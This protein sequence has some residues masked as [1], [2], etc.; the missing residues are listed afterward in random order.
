MEGGNFNILEYQAVGDGKTLC[1]GAIQ[2]AIDDAAKNGGKVIVPAGIYLSGSLQ[3]R[4]HMELHLEEGAVLRCSLREEDMLDFSKDFEDDNADTGWE[5]GC[6]LYA[7]HVKDLTI[8][9][10]GKIDG[11]GREVFFDDD[12]EG[13]PHEGPLNVRGFRP[14]LSFLED[15]ENLCIRDVTFYDAAY[16]TLHLAG[17]RKVRIENI[18]IEN[19]KR[20]V[21]SDGIDPDSCQD[22]IIRGCRIQTGDDS[23]VLKS[24]APMYQKYGD[25]RDILINNCI[26]TTNCSALKI[27]TETYGEVHDVILSDCIVRDCIRG[28]GIWSRDGGRIH[29][30]Y[31]H[32][33]IGTT[34]NFKDCAVRTDGICSWWGEGEP[35]FLSATRRAGVDRIPG[36]IHDIYLDHIHLEGEAPIVMAGETYAPIS[37]VRISDSD[38]V[39]RRNGR[40]VAFSTG[41]DLTSYRKEEG[42]CLWEG[43][44]DERPSAADRKMAKIPYI[45]LRHTEDVQ[46]S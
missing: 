13:A 4:S 44:L 11:Q 41:E 38:F 18:V 8:S 16:W 19:N 17:C 24:T 35:V 31:A 5:G 25:C 34:R 33:I 46:F 29:H 23:I 36:R 39:I 7:C 32:H 9:G 22:V 10:T 15:V 1:T 37:R 12:P 14:R 42:D 2:A 6:F 27:G 40:E 28:I 20:G 21:N 3:L 26:L 45:Y 43:I 30:I